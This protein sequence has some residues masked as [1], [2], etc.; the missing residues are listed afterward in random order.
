M[1][2]YCLVMFRQH[3]ISFYNVI[4]TDGISKCANLTFAFLY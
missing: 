2:Y 4:T 1:K 3:M